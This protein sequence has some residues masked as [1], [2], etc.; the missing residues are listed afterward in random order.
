MPAKRRPVRPVVALPDVEQTDLLLPGDHGTIWT[1]DTVA[2]PA[3]LNVTLPY[4]PH[5]AQRA[6]HDTPGR[7]KVPRCGRRFGKDRWSEQEFLKALFSMAAEP[8]PKHLIPRVH[9]WVVAPTFPMLR[10]M[11]NELRAMLQPTGLIIRKDEAD[12]TLELHGGIFIEFRSADRPE[13]LVGVGLDALWVTEAA[14][15]REIAWTENLRP[16]LSSP[17]R[18]PG[19]RGQGLGIVNSTPRGRNWFYRLCLAGTKA[20]G[21]QPNPLYQPGVTAFHYPSSANPYINPEEIEAARRS[22]PDAIFRQEYLAEFLDDVAAVFVNLVASRTGALK[23]RERGHDYVLGMDLGFVQDYSVIT[24]KDLQTQEVVYLER[25]RDSLLEVQGMRLKAVCEQYEPR[26]CAIDATGVGVPTV[27]Q[28]RQYIDPRIRIHG[29]YYTA[30]T[31]ERLVQQLQLAFQKKTVGL[32]ADGDAD[33]LLDE[34]QSYEYRISKT[35]RFTYNAPDG[36]HDDGVNS[37]MLLEEAAR[38]PGWGVDQVDTL[39]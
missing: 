6:M 32:P 9:G 25:F 7:I 10:Q 20:I 12:Q 26:V 21:G 15:I 2:G 16:T 4:A 3:V 19:M 27:R 29:V 35:G 11:W 31:K 18:G 13:N 38:M 5:P 17:Q 37:L 22:L 36:M 39:F 24:V 28:F 33:W 30:D 34:L 1:P 14:R 8:R 23:P